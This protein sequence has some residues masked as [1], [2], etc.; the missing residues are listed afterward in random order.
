MEV[1]NLSSGNVSTFR[2][3]KFVTK[4]EAEVGP[5]RL[6]KELPMIDYKVLPGAAKG[7]GLLAERG[8]LRG[9]MAQEVGDGE[10]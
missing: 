3:G 1:T 4:E 9:W 5:Q 10:I 8:W 2:F 6:N 7:R